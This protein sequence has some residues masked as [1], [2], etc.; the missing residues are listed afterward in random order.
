MAQSGVPNLSNSVVNLAALREASRKEFT[1]ILDVARGKKAII[2]DPQISGPLGL[3]AEISLLKEHGVE[4]IYYL[5]PGKLE[6]ECKNLIYLVR[7]KVKY[8]R[9]IADQIRQ[10]EQDRQK[11]EYTLCFVPRRTMI[12]ER[13]LEEEGVY[14]DIMISEYRLD[15]I[16]FD[17]DVLSLELDTSYRECL[18]EGDKTSLYY[19]ARA[20]MKLQSTFGIIP[21]VKG[22]GVCSKL[23]YDML[24]RMRK[25]MG[26]DEP[27]TNPE[28]DTLI[29]IDRDVDMVTPCCTQLTYE[30]LVDEVFQINNSLVELEPDIAGVTNAPQGKKI[31]IALNCNDKLYHEIRNMNFTQIGPFLNRKAKE[32]DEYYKSRHGATVSQLRDFTK[33]LSATQQEHTSLRIHTNIAEKILNF[34]REQAFHR[35]LDTEQS[36]LAGTD[37]DNCVEHLEECINRKEP[38]VKVL[39]LLTLL[40]LTNS[41][42]KPKQL[43]FFKREILQTYG[44]E[45]LFTLNNFEKLGLLKRQ[46]KQVFPLMRKGLRLIVEDLD[47]TTP[48]DVAYVYSGYAP[49]SIRLIQQAVRPGGWRAQDELVRALPGPAFE[50][51]QALPPGAVAGTGKDGNPVTLV[52]FIG[53]VTFTEIAALRYMALAE[54]PNR[55]Y[56]VATTKLING[57][58]LIESL[59]ERVEPPRAPSVSTP[60]K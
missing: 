18:L 14:G 41:G 47:E 36:L 4:K 21:N 23:V 56:I 44:F 8:M 48:N 13:V 31:K 25:E 60:R 29:L 11:K 30:G 20:I 32:I 52:F 45:Y 2:L 27:N 49:L 28:I 33:K 46:D 16:P 15:L 38:L 3:V 7:P 22:K 35:R 34:T 40:T 43:E 42:L 59:I 37:F 6:T 10:H 9:I 17:E 58:T 39:R 55:D 54:Q 1:D 50:E 51:T 5:T 19:V 53:G 26:A 12:C 57:D 24:I